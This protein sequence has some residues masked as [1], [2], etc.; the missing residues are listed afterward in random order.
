MVSTRRNVSYQNNKQETT[1]I[2]MCSLPSFHDYIGEL[3]GQGTNGLKTAQKKQNCVIERPDIEDQVNDSTCALKRQRKADRLEQMTV[4]EVQ[5]PKC[6]TPISSPSKKRPCPD[7][8]RID[9]VSKILRDAGIDHH[10]GGVDEDSEEF[11][12]SSRKKADNNIR[13]KSYVDGA[14][15]EFDDLYANYSIV[16]GST[17]KPTYSKIESTMVETPQCMVNLDSSRGALDTPQYLPSEVKMARRQAMLEGRNDFRE[18]LRKSQIDVGL[19]FSSVF[20]TEKNTAREGNFTCSTPKYNSPSTPEIIAISTP[21]TDG[22]GINTPFSW[23]GIRKLV[24]TPLSV[25]A[26]PVTPNSRGILTC[27]TT[28]YN[29]TLVSP[30]KDLPGDIKTSLLSEVICFVDVRTDKENMTESVKQQL[31]SLGAKVEKN[32]TKKVT[33]VIFKEGRISTYLKAKKENIP[34]VSVLW[35]EACKIAMGVVDPKA[36]PPQR[37]EK[38]EDILPFETL[39]KRRQPKL[40]TTGNPMGNGN[41][42][43]SAKS[44]FNRNAVSEAKKVQ[45]GNNGI[46]RY[47]IKKL[48]FGPAKQQQEKNNIVELSDDN[49]SDTLQ[50][51]GKFPRRQ[52]APANL[53]SKKQRKKSNRVQDGNDD[54]EKMGENLNEIDN[55]KSN[56][57]TLVNGGAT[58]GTS[59]SSN[60]HKLFN[61]RMS[62]LSQQLQPSVDNTDTPESGS[63]TYSVY[64]FPDKAANNRGV[65]TRLTSRRMRAKKA[66]P[67]RAKKTLDVLSEMEEID[68]FR[69]FSR[70]S[71]SVFVGAKKNESPANDKH[72]PTIVLTRFSSKDQ[73]QL[74]CIIKELGIFLIESNVTINTTHLVANEPRRTLNMIKAISRG[75]WILR[76]DWVFKSKEAGK[77][78]NEEEFEMVDFSPA[79]LRCELRAKG[80]R[81]CNLVHDRDK[82]GLERSFGSRTKFFLRLCGS[83][84]QATTTPLEAAAPTPDYTIMAQ[85][86]VNIIT[87]L[88]IFDGNPGDLEELLTTAAQ[89]GAH[90]E[91]IDQ[92][93]SKAIR[94]SVYGVLLRRLSPAIRADWGIEITTDLASVRRKLK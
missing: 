63:S 51:S 77:W 74:E 78:L 33:H 46:E 32:F 52:S 19:Y 48:E 86:A 2:D 64:P 23:S 83:M 79:V 75:C 66:I 37:M 90:L 59:G 29:L 16:K 71:M 65:R 72:T 56:E 26:S 60:R 10:C 34:M 31:T 3:N 40:R 89:A 88:P 80:D 20:S 5:D 36:F 6:S 7:T 24:L 22:T 54:N 81:S 9:A 18:I 30:E 39:K 28:P 42:E 14:F 53:L 85:L 82:A 92:S 70:S 17:P 67:T 12:K 8:P 47:C 58:C 62:Y 35:I 91:A 25:N 50:H 11:F 73:N 43:S 57:K 1:E 4:T 87:L 84:E 44:K 15:E 69:Y 49:S 21:K 41:C 45:T 93:L 94:T 55:T 38:Y 68:S 13:T 76:S 27:A 61:P